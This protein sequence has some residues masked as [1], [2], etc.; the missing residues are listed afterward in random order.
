MIVVASLHHI[1]VVV[2]DLARAKA[3][4][5]EVL[6]LRELSRS[7]SSAPGNG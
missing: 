4:Y 3:F 1:S 7:T 2:T 5:G 6:G